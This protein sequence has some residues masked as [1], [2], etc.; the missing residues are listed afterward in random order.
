[1]PAPQAPA[2]LHPPGGMARLKDLIITLAL[3]GY[4]TLGFCLIFA[5]FYLWVFLFAKNK[6]P[7]FQQL[8]SRFL[9]GFF[10]LCRLLIPKQQWHI[11]PDVRRIRGAIVLCNHI[12]YLDSILMVSLFARH[13]TIAKAQL[14][15][16][17]LMGLNLHMAGYIPS[18]AQG[19]HGHIL[20]QRLDRLPDFMAGGGNLILFPEGTRSRTGQ[21]G[22]FHKGG[23]KIA[24][25]CQ[26]P[27][28]VVT[29]RNTNHLF[30]PDRFLFH[31][32][33]ANTIEV[34]LAGTL[35]PD[36]GHPDFSIQALM[37]QTRQLLARAPEHNAT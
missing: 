18:S 14:F 31:T 24:R 19:R 15:T 13:T 21:V 28:K 23:F 8:N 29:I 33:G 12:S 4:F 37:D 34:K 11:D 10:A 27:I 36:Y 17:P 26:A 16:I 3:W 32:S 20:Q 2:H 1:M 25:M 22:P 5:P 30:P 35:T 6:Q 7:A 9:K